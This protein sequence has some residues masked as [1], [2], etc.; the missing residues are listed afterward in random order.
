MG[1]GVI[2]PRWDLGGACLVAA[3]AAAAG[4][5]PPGRALPG[6]GG[7]A[8]G[9]A[10]RSVALEAH[11][12]ASEDLALPR[13]DGDAAGGG[14]GESREQ[15]QGEGLHAPYSTPH[16]RLHKAEGRRFISAAMSRS[17]VLLLLALSSLATACVG[18]APEPHP[19]P[20]DQCAFELEVYPVLARDCGFPACHGTMHRAFQVFAPG[21]TRLDPMTPQLDGPTDDEIALTYDR[22]RSMLGGAQS[23]DDAPLL[24]KPLAIEAGGA[25]HMGRDELGRDVYRS[26]EDPDF[27]TIR[28]WAHGRMVTCP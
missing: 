9:G 25:G 23:V 10:D 12:G 1:I 17:V 20:V 13:A 14:D 22:A 21:R 16:P 15:E 4:S 7:V 6:L 11:V 27:V 28:D 2:S 5:E 18:A 26:K 24:R 3:A 19:P 8:L